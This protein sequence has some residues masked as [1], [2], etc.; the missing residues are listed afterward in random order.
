[1]RSQLVEHG[2]DA[3]VGLGVVAAVRGVGGTLLGNGLLKECRV[4]GGEPFRHVALHELLD[5]VADHVLVL[6]KAVLGPAVRSAHEVGGEREVVERVEQ[7]S[8]HV[9]DHVAKTHGIPSC[10]RRAVLCGSLL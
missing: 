5:A 3:G 2:G 8:V 6:G 9:E 4:R 1:M 10:L 7:R